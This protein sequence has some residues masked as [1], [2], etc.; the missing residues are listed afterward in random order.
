MSRMP[1]GLSTRWPSCA[2]GKIR[3]RPSSLLPNE[4]NGASYKER[5]TREV[6]TP[7]GILSSKLGKPI[8]H[9]AYPYGD[10]S[11][12]VMD[13]LQDRHY[14]TGTT[15]QRGGNPS[16]ADPLILRRDMVYSDD[17]LADFQK[18]VAVRVDMKLR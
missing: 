4:Q 18:Y 12:T 14:E 16:F 2:R 7:D 15:V 11:P 6:V 9:F 1:V 13:I 17:K 3:R 8:K 10:T 5:V